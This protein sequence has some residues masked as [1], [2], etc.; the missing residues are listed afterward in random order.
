MSIRAQLETIL[1]NVE[2][3]AK[4]LNLQIPQLKAQYE[5]AEEQL[6]AVNTLIATI[7]VNLA[8]GAVAEDAIATQLTAGDAPAAEAPCESP[9]VGLPVEEA[10]T[11]A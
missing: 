4:Q 3:N 7:K 6:S 5:S 11:P 9:V 10:P 1:A 2:N 8:G